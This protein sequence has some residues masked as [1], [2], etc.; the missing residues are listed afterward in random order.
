MDKDENEGGTK[1]M[2]IRENKGITLIALVITIIVL[3]ILAA[4]TLNLI[5]GE[6]GIFKMA[7]EAGRNYTN[8]QNA[9]LADLEKLENMDWYTGEE[10]KPLYARLYKDGTLILSSSD[11]IDSSREISEDY[12]DI[13]KNEYK[14]SL[15]ITFMQDIEEKL[16]GD[17]P[18][19]IEVEND[20]KGNLVP[21]RNKAENVIIYDKI[22]PKNMSIWFYEMNELITLDL[23]NVDTS[24]VTDM[25]GMFTG[26]SLSNID[27][28]DF[29]T[30]RVTNMSS[31]FTRCMKLSNIDLSNFDTSKVTNMSGMFLGC[32]N[33][34]NI[35]LSSFN[36][37][38]V[39]NMIGMFLGCIKLSNIDLSNFD[40]SKV[41]NMSSMFF[42]CMNLTNIDLSN[43]DTSKVTDMSSM[44][45]GTSLTNID[46]S[47]FDTSQV[48]NMSGMFFSMRKF[49]QYRFKSF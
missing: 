30:S 45:A 27:L 21:K 38:Q 3:L 26:T 17:Y 15:H 10:T 13:S 6:R 12:G 11:Y 25:S 44:F 43:F 29:D 9:E 18:G 42:G 23:A 31:M 1:E 19:W 28:S 37:S 7:E 8:A 49:N 46:L 24:K 2:K 35:D 22:E 20:E 40:T 47:H 5:I 14:Y 48:T 39:T 4:I 16:E 33:L 36:T 34:S 32:M 41:T